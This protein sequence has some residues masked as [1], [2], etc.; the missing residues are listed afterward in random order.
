VV[1]NRQEQ[2]R[3]YLLGQ[4]SEE[5]AVQF[6]DQYFVDNDV[7]EEMTGLEDEM[8]DSFVRGELPGKDADKF[9]EEYLT[10]PARQAKAGFAGMLARHLSDSAKTSSVPPQPSRK[11]ISIFP[12]IFFNRRYFAVM[13]AALLLIAWLLVANLRLRH[14]LQQLR[15]QQVEFQRREQDLRKQV[16]APA[17]R[18]EDRSK[19]LQ[20]HQNRLGPGSPAKNP[21]ESNIVSLILS[22]GMAR[23]ADSPKILRTSSKTLTAQLQLLLEPENLAAIAVPAPAPS[24]TAQHAVPAPVPSTTVQ[25]DDYSAYSVSVETAAGTVVWQKDGLKT[26]AVSGAKAITIRLPLRILRN[27]N[28]RVKLTAARAAGGAE[29]VGDYRFLVVKR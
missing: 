23:S 19:D 4:M 20:A 27:G 12:Q 28:Y 29:D 22:P 7:F 25:Y 24:T 15:T 6:E 13:A 9:Q 8:L 18:S 10:S 1:E 3:R 2:A 14:E 26:Q 5:D 17:G 16:V 11:G 21:E